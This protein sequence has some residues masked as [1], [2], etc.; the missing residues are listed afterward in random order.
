MIEYHFVES[1]PN[2]FEKTNVMKIKKCENAENM[3]KFPKHVNYFEML[4]VLLYYR[5][6]VR[7]FLT[8]CYV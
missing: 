1:G 5:Q 7:G 4:S 6:N 2:Q 8:E 3:F